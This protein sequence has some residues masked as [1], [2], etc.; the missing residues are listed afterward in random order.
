MA[1]SIAAATATAVDVMADTVINIV[2]SECPGAVVSCSA[3]ATAVATAAAACAVAAR[4]RCANAVTTCAARAAATADSA[5][6]AAAAAATA[7]VPASTVLIVFTL[8]VDAADAHFV[9]AAAYGASAGILH[10]KK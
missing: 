8:I 9:G 5:A 7:A 2:L 6:A 4:S 1:T 10:V 3:M